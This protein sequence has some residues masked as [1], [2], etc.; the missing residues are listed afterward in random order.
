MKVLAIYG[1][2]RKGGNTDTLMDEAIKG[3]LEVSPG[4]EV[5]RVRAV[6]M[7]I[8]AC[9]ACGDCD[10]AGVCSTDDG[11]HPLYDSLEGADILLIS[12]PVFFMGVPAQLKAM[13]DRCQCLWVKNHVL[14][15]ERIGRM[16]PRVAALLSA[17]GQE[18]EKN[19]V[20]LDHAM[21]SWTGSLGF[22]Y[23]EKMFVDRK[24]RFGAVKADSTILNNA[25][26]L[27]HRLVQHLERRKK[28][29]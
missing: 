14:D 20:G 18:Q 7:D 26:E 2:P 25:R 5:E 11:M 4:A 24:D 1:S 8:S 10:D 9:K 15:K 17:A 28:E 16:G 29:G 27:G 23:D 6:D 13:I 22:H 19:F 12:S 21:I 3:I